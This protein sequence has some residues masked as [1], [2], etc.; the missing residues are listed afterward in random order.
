MVNRELAEI[1]GSFLALAEFAKENRGVKQEL[2]RDRLIDLLEE[3]E[4]YVQANS[5]RLS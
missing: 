4:N 1:L 2:L 5:R 3:F